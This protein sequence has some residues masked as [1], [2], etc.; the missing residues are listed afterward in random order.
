MFENGL[1]NCLNPNY[2]V[3]LSSTKIKPKVLPACVKSRDG[4]LSWKFLEIIPFIPKE[5]QIEV[6]IQVYL[7][8]AILVIFNKILLILLLLCYF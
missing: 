6:C 8:S 7:T 4:C 5:E 3:K 2:D 1:L